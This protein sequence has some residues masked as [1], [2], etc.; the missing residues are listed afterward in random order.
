MGGPVGP[1]PTNFL[2]G[3][4]RGQMVSIRAYEC[5]CVVNLEQCEERWNPE[6]QLI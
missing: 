1:A 3:V 6:Q 2:M 5:S 4:L